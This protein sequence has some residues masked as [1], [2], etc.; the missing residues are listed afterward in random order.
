MMKK[1]GTNNESVSGDKTLQSMDIIL[2]ETF[3]GVTV[4]KFFYICWK[5]DES[6]PLYG[7]WLESIGN[8]NVQ[9]SAWETRDEDDLFVGGWDQEQYSMKRV[10]TFQKPPSVFSSSPISVKHT[11]HCRYDDKSCIVS[12]M[13]ETEGVPFANAF[14][15]EIRWV[16]TKDDETNDLQIEVG[17]FVVFTKS[18]M[19]AGQIRSKTKSS[20]TKMQSGLL[21]CM[22][23]ACCGANL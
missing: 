23:E 2:R 18:V 17:L 1:K 13:V 21:S 11:Q 3:K 9:A 6:S 4:D 20:T 10:V 8:L 7:P 16:A 19:L 12:M 14:H 22:K 15:V 5:E